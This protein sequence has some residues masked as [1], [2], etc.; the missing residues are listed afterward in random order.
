MSHL[1]HQG[2]SFVGTENSITRWIREIKEGDLD[3][4]AEALWREYFTKLVRYARQKLEGH[5]RRVADEEDVALSAFKSFCLA[6]QKGRFPDLADRDGLWRLL[7]RMTARKAVDLIRYQA[8]QKR[9]VVG[10]SEIVKA[11][12]DSPDQAIAQVIGDAPTPEFSAM[13]SEECGRL[14]E[15]LDDPELKTIALAKMEGHTNPEIAAKLD[16]AV[17]TVERQLQLIR[18]KWQA[19]LER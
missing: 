7:L 13:V 16:C 2:G 12:S 10:E 11:D 1:R 9:K 3:G 15:L 14:L 8:R 18:K 6:A 19:E 17:R 5:P 4:A